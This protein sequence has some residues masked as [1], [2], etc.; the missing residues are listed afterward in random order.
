MLQMQKCLG[1]IKSFRS[2]KLAITIGI[3]GLILDILTKW[4]VVSN[5]SFGE[6]I[7]VFPFFNLVRVHNYGITFGV[8]YDAVPSYA[9]AIVSC[10]VIFCLVYWANKEREYAPFIILVIFGA[11]GNIIDRFLYGYVVDFLDFFILQYHW[12]AFNIADC[13]IVFGNL[14]LLLILLCDNN[15][16]DLRRKK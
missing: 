15:K 3:I 6:S 13:M 4:W 1:F 14:N 11:L 8:L 5:F 7:S 12:P 2:L 9:L 16:R 10:I